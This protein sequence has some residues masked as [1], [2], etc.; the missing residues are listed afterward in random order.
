MEFAKNSLGRSTGRRFN[1]A[2]IKR[3]LDAKHN[4][5]AFDEDRFEQRRRK[6]DRKPVTISFGHK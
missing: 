5:P 1:M 2:A 6:R 3:E 4:R